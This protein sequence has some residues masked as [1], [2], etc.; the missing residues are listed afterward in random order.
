MFIALEQHWPAEKSRCPFYICKP[1]FTN[2]KISGENKTK[3]RKPF[4]HKIRNIVDI[5]LLTA[6]CC[7]FSCLSFSS[8]FQLTSVFCSKNLKDDREVEFWLSSFSAQ[9]PPTCPASFSLLAFL[10]LPPAL[11]PPAADLSL[12]PGNR[13][14]GNVTQDCLLQLQRNKQDRENSCCYI[15][16][17]M[18][19]CTKAR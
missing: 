8:K 1:A 7:F 11:P 13:T 16:T 10:S 9:P 17:V 2:K 5:P 12:L 14:T 6:F 3:N 18:Y 19:K 4:L 15:R